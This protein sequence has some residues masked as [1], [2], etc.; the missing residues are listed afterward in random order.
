MLRV[1]IVYTDEWDSYK[2][3]RPVLLTRLSP[4]EIT[5]VNKYYLYAIYLHS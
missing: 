5:Q 4:S 2:D 1:W 3:D